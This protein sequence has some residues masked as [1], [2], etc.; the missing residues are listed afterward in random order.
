M[1]QSLIGSWMK[2]IT[3]GYAPPRAEAPGIPLPLRPKRVLKSSRIPMV[4]FKMI[5]L[6]KI[7][8]L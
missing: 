2:E 1:T 4:V 8:E 5:E 3:A 6:E 7:E